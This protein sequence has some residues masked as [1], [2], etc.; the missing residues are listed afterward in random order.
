[1]SRSLFKPVFVSPLLLRQLYTILK[2]TPEK[3]PVLQIFSRSSTILPDFVGLKVMIH[4]GMRFTTIVINKLMINHKFGE[5]AYCKR[6]GVKI[7]RV[8]K[9]S[10]KKA[11]SKTK[12]KS[13]PK[14]KPKSKTKKLKKR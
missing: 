2:L 10:D 4:N 11:K 5:F 9:S 3:R 1:M 12:P 14:L 8:L 6:M 7:H 13:K